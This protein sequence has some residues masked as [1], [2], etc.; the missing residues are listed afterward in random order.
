MR[1][2]QL[3][4]A[5]TKV[6]V[7]IRIPANMET[8]QKDIKEDKTMA[9]SEQELKKLK[10]EIE[11]LRERLKG[12]S[13]DELERVVGGNAASLTLHPF[14]LSTENLDL[15]TLFTF[16]MTQIVTDDRNCTK[17]N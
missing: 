11:R 13:D 15:D 7:R 5:N 1:R 6:P 4:L 2:R 16:N 10:E 3:T 8:A 9:K 12:L 14:N 17:R